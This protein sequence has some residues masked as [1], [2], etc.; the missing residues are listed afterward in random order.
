MNRMLVVVFS[1]ASK[2]FDG[3]EAIKSLDR[4]GAVTVY[5]CA[6]ITKKADGTTVVNEEDDFGRLGR[7]LGLQSG[8]SLDFLADRLELPLAP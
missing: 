2:A 7:C 6:L 4:D 1:E 8:A 5:A 3:R